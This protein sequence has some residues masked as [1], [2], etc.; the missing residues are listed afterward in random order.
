MAQQRK[1]VGNSSRVACKQYAAQMKKDV[2]GADEEQKAMRKKEGVMRIQALPTAV[3]HGSSKSTAKA[4]QEKLWELP[5]NM[6]V[7]PSDQ[8]LEQVLDEVLSQLK[9]SWTA[10]DEENGQQAGFAKHK[11]DWPKE[12]K[13]GDSSSVKFSSLPTKDLG[14]RHQHCG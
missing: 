13:T 12:M 1:T 11:F 4:F 3:V 8:N 14:Q 2:L 5:D 6:T 10:L 7:Y 9:S